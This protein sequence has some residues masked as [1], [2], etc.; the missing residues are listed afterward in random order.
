[1]GERPPPPLLSARMGTK[2]ILGIAAST[3]GAA[4]ELTLELLVEARDAILG[5]PRLTAPDL[6][7]TLTNAELDALEDRR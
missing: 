2:G 6:L 4:G 5:P 7:G 3:A 1:M